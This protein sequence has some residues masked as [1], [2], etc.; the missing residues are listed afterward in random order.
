MNSQQ[1]IQSALLL[2]AFVLLAGAYGVLYSMGRL[3]ASSALM[4]A[5]YGCYALQVLVTAMI[6]AFAPLAPGWRL[7][8]VLS[9]LVVFKIPSITWS[10]LELTHKRSEQ[11]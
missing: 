2:G 11:T 9:C 1:L 10:Y 3:K 8:V 7:L 5:A 6:A 4:K